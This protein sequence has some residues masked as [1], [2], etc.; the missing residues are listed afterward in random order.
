MLNRKTFIVKVCGSCVTWL[1]FDR[2]NEF[3]TTFLM[4]APHWMG[5][6]PRVWVLPTVQ[7]PMLPAESKH[8]SI[9]RYHNAKCWAL[10]R[11]TTTK[12]LVGDSD[13]EFQELCALEQRDGGL[14]GDRNDVDTAVGGAESDH[15]TL[16][17]HCHR[18][19]TISSA[20]VAPFLQQP[21]NGSNTKPPFPTFI[22]KFTSLELD[23]LRCTPEWSP[24]YNAL[25]N[26]NIHT[27]PYLRMVP[28][29]W[30]LR[31]IAASKKSMLGWRK[32]ECE[33]RGFLLLRKNW[34][35]FLGCV[36]T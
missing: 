4:Q 7:L 21:S 18:H 36:C 14:V 20:A 28:T 10:Q 16:I 1:K 29:C 17:S 3:G 26:R 35:S 33:G 13:G 12:I 24:N 23:P 19:L 15:G 31:K 9:P 25:R 8:Y 32:A 27:S 22:P 5:Q 30:I 11:L 6:R 2:W 34:C